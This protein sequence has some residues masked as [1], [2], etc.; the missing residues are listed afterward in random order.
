M[1]KTDSF[2]PPIIPLPFQP[3]SKLEK[4]MAAFRQ[5][6]P[7]LLNEYR[8]QFVAIHEEKMV[9]NGPD[10][11]SVAMAA[12]DRFGYQPIYVDLVTEE[13]MPPVRVPH[14]K[15]LSVRESS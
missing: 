6:L 8:G 10:L 13:R 5:L 7:E 9:A 14:Y 2:P 11:V 12:Y 3:R 1:T 4:E 15:M